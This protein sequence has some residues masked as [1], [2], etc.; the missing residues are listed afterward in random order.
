[1]HTLIPGLRLEV[2]HLPTFIGFYVG[3]G[4]ARFRADNVDLDRRLREERV[5]HVFEVYSGAHM[6]A[7]WQRHAERWLRLALHPLAKP[8]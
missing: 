8:S 4:D 3:N 2:R 6:A 1:V 5:P 7:L